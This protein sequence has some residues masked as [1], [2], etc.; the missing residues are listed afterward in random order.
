MTEITFVRM[1]YDLVP[2]EFGSAYIQIGEAN[3]YY[4]NNPLAA[5]AAMRMLAQTLGVEVEFVE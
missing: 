5:W 4:P 1:T 3:R 2:T